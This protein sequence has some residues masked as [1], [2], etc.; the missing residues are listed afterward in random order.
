MFFWVA[1]RTFSFWCF[2]MDYNK[3]T[4]SLIFLEGFRSQPSRQG[5]V[6]DIH[7]ALFFRTLKYGDYGIFLTVCNALTLKPLN[8]KGLNPKP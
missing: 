3:E 1:L 8:P 2:Y 6:D 5:T 4:N 7:P